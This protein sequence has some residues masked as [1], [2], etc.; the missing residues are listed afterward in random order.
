MF[1]YKIYPLIHQ[2]YTIETYAHFSSASGLK[3]ETLIAFHNT[4]IIII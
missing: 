2:P 1:T 3:E 4:I